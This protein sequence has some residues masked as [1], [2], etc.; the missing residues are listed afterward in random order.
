MGG[1]CLLK[2][3]WRKIGMV[4]VGEPARL[5]KIAKKVV[6]EEPEP[7]ILQRHRSTSGRAMN[8]GGRPTLRF[9]SSLYF[10]FQI[11]SGKSYR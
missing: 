2:R 10:C 3:D 6:W 8:S 4:L 5:F 11:Y 1:L 7:W 9:L